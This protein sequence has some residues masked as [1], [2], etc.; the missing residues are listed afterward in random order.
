MTKRTNW[1]SM[2]T[3]PRD[4]TVII[5]AENHDDDRFVIF[6][7]VYANMGGGNPEAGEKA[8][9]SIG[10]WGTWPSRRTGEGGDIDLPVRWRSIAAVPHCWTPLPE[11]MD[12]ESLALAL[13]VFEPTD[14]AAILDVIAE[15]KRQDAKWGGPLSDDQRNHPSDWCRLIQDYAGWARTM[16]SMD[17]SEKYRKR[18]VQIAALAVAAIESHDRL[19]D[20]GQPEQQGGE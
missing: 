1:N 6:P 17:S 16:A 12:S 9:G 5:V 3:A 11:V 4:G 7:A 13:E 2:D 19:I 10:W 20:L 8:E 15:R 14:D 18:M